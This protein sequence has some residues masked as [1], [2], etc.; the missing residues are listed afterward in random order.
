MAPQV[1]VGGQVDTDGQTVTPSVD[2]TDSLVVRGD[3]A[4]T[5]LV[6]SGYDGSTAGSIHADSSTPDE[7]VALSLDQQNQVVLVNVCERPIVGRC[8]VADHLSASSTP[9]SNLCSAG[10]VSSVSGSG[11]WTRSCRGSGGGTDASCDA[12]VAWRV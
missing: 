1:F 4:T 3:M 11:P 8:G 10:T 2:H 5:S 6:L 12:L 7:C 9:S